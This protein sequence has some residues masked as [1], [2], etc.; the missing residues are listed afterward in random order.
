MSDLL[1]ETE[2]RNR[3]RYDGRVTSTGAYYFRAEYS[4]MEQIINYLA[5]IGLF[6]IEIPTEVWM[7]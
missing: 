6:L 7:K 4:T 1:T 5:F 3:D 2:L